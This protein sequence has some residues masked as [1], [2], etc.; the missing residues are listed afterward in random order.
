MKPVRVCET[1]L[2][3]VLNMR[4]GIRTIPMYKAKTTQ[5]QRFLLFIYTEHDAHTNDSFEWT[6]KQ[7]EAINYM[8]LDEWLKSD[9]AR[10]YEYHMRLNAERC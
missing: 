9:A 1:S 10:G 7:A 8:G 6:R 3:C 5:Q 4:Q 2:R